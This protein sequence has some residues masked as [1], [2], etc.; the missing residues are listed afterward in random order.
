MSQRRRPLVCPIFAL[1]LLGSACGVTGTKTPPVVEPQVARPAARPVPDVPRLPAEPDGV[2]SLI[3]RSQARF[4]A[5]QRELQLGHLDRARAEFN[6]AL[7][8]L[9]ESPSGAHA[10]ARLQE[11]FERLVDRI[12]AYEIR[13]LMAGDGFAEQPDLP[14][15]L[16]ELLDL[17]PADMV[18]PKADL[19]DAVELDL[20]STAH[21]IPIPL[22]GKILSYIELF[23]GRL[24]DWFQAALQRGQPHMPMIEAALR[25][26]GLP[27][28]LAFI[29]IVESAF[30]TNALSRAKA[31]GVWQLMRG[32]AVEQ[33]LT[34]N[35]YIDER[36][37]PEKATAAAVKYLRVLNRMFKGD[38]H[39]TLA[40]YNG[41]PGKVQR[42]IKQRGVNDFWR[43]AEKGTYLARE[44]REY[45]PM[46]LAAMVVA[47][48]PA[49]YGFS[50]EPAAVPVTDVVQVPGPVDLRRIAEWAGAPLEEI[51]RL[52]P[53]LRR[54]TT[55]L[56]G[57]GYGIRVPAGTAEA[58]A[59]QLAASEPEDLAALQYHTV[60]RG[61]SITTIAT[62]L[63]VKRADLAEA[64]YLTLRSRVKPG[65][66]LVIPRMPTTLLAARTEPAAP[67]TRTVAASS[68]GPRGQADRVKVTYRVRK[69]DSLYSIART[70]KTT[71]DE[72]RGWNDIK[73]THIAAGDRLTVY[74]ARS[75]GSRP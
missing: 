64:N 71:V 61:E 51:Q 39:L 36:S 65:D 18:P 40:S 44:T 20:R 19:K 68:A 59:V 29:P 5:G 63:R 49:Q 1:A 54:L 7:D 11:H 31:K 32:T 13:A 55:P 58:V 56:R 26:E 33:G 15:S 6:A 52:N 42:A 27:L 17:A 41:G 62:K 21:D 2:Q 12:S 75:G 14:A 46:V 47:R 74:T 72:L 48:N 16:D 8:V 24:R 60:K 30:H 25:A 3:D 69:G 38:W 23:Q 9:L 70:F 67:V 35:W 45:V 43:L 50:V 66:R 37:D 22:N 10:D 34:H 73:G 57:A 28:D 4:D 53:E